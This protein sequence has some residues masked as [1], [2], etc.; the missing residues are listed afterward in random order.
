MY[1]QEPRAHAVSAHEP[2]S[3]R[4]AAINQQQTVSDTNVT[5]PAGA[6]KN[7]RDWYH[8]IGEG[9]SLDYVLAKGL[10]RGVP[11]SN[12]LRNFLDHSWGASFS[13]LLL[14]FFLIRN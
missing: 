6:T 3:I 7:K 14:S 12:L 2:S 9:E 5:R 4:F 8:K 1:A 10:L 11:I 13:T